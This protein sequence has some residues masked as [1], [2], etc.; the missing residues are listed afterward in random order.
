MLRYVGKRLVMMIPI[1]L[2]VIFV[3]FFIME[4]T[5]GDPALRILG[6]EA[7]AEAL[8][9]LRE[10]L[11]INKPFLERFVD[12][13][14]NVFT[15]LDFGTSW[16][17]GNPVFEDI[18]PRIMVSVK[19]G[20]YGIL[21]ATLL[22]VPLGVVSAVKQDS[23][24][25]GIL[26]VLSTVTVAMP[27]F[28]LAMLLILGF[29]LHWRIFPPGGVDHWYSYILPMVTAGS[30][31][32]CS[33][34]RMTRST[35]LE[36]IR[37]DYIRTARAKGVP[38][39]VVTYKHAL[40]NALLPV[41]T[42]IGSCFGYIVGSSVVTETVFSIPGLGSLAV[43]S[44]KAKDSPVVIVTVLLIAFFFAI[45]MLGVDLLYAFVDPRIRAKY[46][47]KN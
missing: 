35:M 21:F 44:I 32:A 15:K 22:G 6:P 20:L 14:V 16:R 5:P 47:K 17:T 28:W 34:L 43:L 38:D 41:I 46:A 27:T 23:A 11:G 2:G 26:R 12:Y 45:I 19:L 39:R 42:T 24:G 9:A 31:Y 4:I 3:I 29:A 1:M 33:I 40:K 13:L 25:D 37:Q 10:Q 8:E 30:S 36:E 7:G 18:A